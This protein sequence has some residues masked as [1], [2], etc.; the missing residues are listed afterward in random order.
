MLRLARAE[1]QAAD[2]GPRTLERADLASTCE[3][4]VARIKSLAAARAVA[5][6][7][8]VQDSGEVQ[9]D[10]EDLELVWVNL[11]E[12][13]IQ[14]SPPGSAVRLRL[15]RVDDTACVIV[16][17]WG[18]GIAAEDLPYIFERFR[19]GDR[20]RSR[21]TGGF[22][23]GLAIAKAIVEAYGGTIQAESTLQEGTR[24]WV[25]LPI[26]QQSESQSAAVE[27]S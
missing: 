13:A 8:D 5:V 1:Q 7:L 22:G 15:E 11:L 27:S 25:R 21:E 12:N 6:Q 17:D 16:Q 14:H 2:G 24:V 18:T 20:S 26:S 23:L 9:A 4:A 19:R 3:M 10:A